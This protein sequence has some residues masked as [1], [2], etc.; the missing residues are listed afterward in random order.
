VPVEKLILPRSKI[1]FSPR[2][3]VVNLSERVP[4]K[5]RDT[6]SETLALPEYPISK[7]P[8]SFHFRVHSCISVRQAK[9][10]FSIDLKCDQHV[11]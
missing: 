5:M 11:K 9:T 10:G 3:L 1:S 8:M 6:S 2:P 4:R 7:F